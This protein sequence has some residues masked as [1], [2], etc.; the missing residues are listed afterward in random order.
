MGLLLTWGEEYVYEIV[1]VNYNKWLTLYPIVSCM[2]VVL[3]VSLATAAVV[4]AS[5]MA[6]SSDTSSV[7]SL[8]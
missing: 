4:S 1:A 2:S 5:L 8:V 7:S 6:T 3:T